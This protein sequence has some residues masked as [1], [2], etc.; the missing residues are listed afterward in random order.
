MFSEGIESHDQ[1]QDLD[2]VWIDLFGFRS[3]H[4]V[5]FLD[6]FQPINNQYFEPI[7][8]SQLIF[9]ANGFTG[10]NMTIIFTAKELTHHELKFIT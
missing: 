4:K 1:V 10:F 8:T 7:E 9:H 3:R 6:L 5:S 2:F